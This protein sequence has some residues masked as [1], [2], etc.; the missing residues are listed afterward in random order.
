MQDVR[1]SAGHGPRFW[2]G[3]GGLAVAALVSA[4]ALGPMPLSLVPSEEASP[5]APHLTWEDHGRVVDDALARG[6]VSAAVRAW[7]D[8]YGAALASRRWD[9]PLAAGDTFVRVGA[10]T[11]VIEAAKP[12]ARR[13]YLGALVRA[14]QQQQSIDGV[15]RVA[16]AFRALGDG[17]AAA[18]CERIAEAL[19]APRGAR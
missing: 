11:G 4:V 2:I 12:N 19:A 8:L 1:D 16:E 13:A 18:F 3:L 5:A 10:A 9:A 6:D 17:E 14:Q 7:H 15:Q